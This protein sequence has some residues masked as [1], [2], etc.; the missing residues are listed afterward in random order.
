MNAMTV[1][2]VPLISEPVEKRYLTMG[3]CALVTGGSRGIGKGIAIVLAH[4]GY[5]L[6][7]TYATALDEA[8]ETAEKIRLAGRRCFIYQASLEQA[9]VPAAIVQSAIKDLGHIDLLVNN[10]GLTRRGPLRTVTVE[11]LDFIYQLNWRA[12]LLCAQAAA[13]HMIE[14]NIRGNIINIASTRGIRAYP[15][16]HYYGGMKA[17]LIRSSESMALELSRYGIRVNVVAPGATMVRGDIS[18]EKAGKVSWAGKVPLGRF[19]TPEEV[20]HLV[21]YLASEHAAYITGA[22][23]KIDGGLILPGMPEDASPEAGYGWAGPIKDA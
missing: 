14:N 8:R 4:E 15:D 10:A 16:D 2:S 13:N 19:G 5:D 9:D 6:A 20:G 11:Q 3:L 17:A 22:V 1:Q 18:R 7:I 12:P 21:A 23:V